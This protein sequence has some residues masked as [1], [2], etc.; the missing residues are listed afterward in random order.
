L[1]FCFVKKIFAVVKKENNAK[2][3]TF[4]PSHIL[5]GAKKNLY[6]IIMP[7]ARHVENVRKI[8]LPAAKIIGAHSLNLKP[9]FIPHC[10][11][12]FKK[13]FPGGVCASK[14]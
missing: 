12:C 13:L 3:Y 5:G 8:T 7:S 10:K 1:I 11:N 14:T 4:S 6:Q 9:I 2:F